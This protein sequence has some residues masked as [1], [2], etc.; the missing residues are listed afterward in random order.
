MLM[1]VSVFVPSSTIAVT[2]LPP[3]MLGL[4]V[5]SGLFAAPPKYHN[6][7]DCMGL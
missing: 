2:G 6:Q 3:R 1:L 7:G 4:A 5:K